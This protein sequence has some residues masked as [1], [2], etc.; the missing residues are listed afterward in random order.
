LSKEYLLG[1]DVGTASIKVGIF[2]VKGQIRIFA[3]MPFRIINPELNYCEV[4][5][6]I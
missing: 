1:I 2:S 6:T 5:L 3:T 4:S